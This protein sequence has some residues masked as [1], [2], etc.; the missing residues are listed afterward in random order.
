VSTSKE[1]HW[2]P[3]K[4]DKT[5]R[6]GGE[7]SKHNRKFKRPRR[8]DWMPDNLDDLDALDE[9]DFSQRERIAPRG[10]RERRQA[11]IAAMLADLEEEMDA[12]EL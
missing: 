5:E 7:Q 10:E 8:R 1:G 9:F 11:I 6:R 2:R 4:V 3:Q 12:E